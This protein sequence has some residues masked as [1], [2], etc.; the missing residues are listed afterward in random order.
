[1]KHA[2]TGKLN[3][4]RLCLR[5]F[6]QS[7]AQMM[8]DNWACDDEV[9]RYLLWFSH[10]EVAETEEVI[11]DWVSQYAALDYYHWVI[12]HETTGEAIGS[13]NLFDIRRPL[14]SPWRISAEVGYCLGK[15]WW[16][17]GFASEAVEEV[18]SYAFECL[19]VDLVVARHD[20]RNPASGGVMKKL[21]MSHM[22]SVK[23]AERGRDGKW[24]DCDY[25]QIKKKDYLKKGSG[26]LQKEW[27]AMGASP[28][29]FK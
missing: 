25:Y 27:K 11:S 4:K 21:S 22:K 15:A 8:F 28:N 18:L 17:K 10:R 3:T 19:G 13:I 7:D 14:L 20:H 6:Q 12:I 24:I 5:P 1:M 26:A 9:T 23:K 16:G 29:I 2:G